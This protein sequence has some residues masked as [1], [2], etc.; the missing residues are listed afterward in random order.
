[1]AMRCRCPPEN[2]V[3]VAVYH[4]R[5]QRHFFEHRR[6]FVGALLP[7]ELRLVHQEAFADDFADGQ[8]WRERAVGILKDDLHVGFEFLP[9]F[10]R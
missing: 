7:R 2:F 3:R 9:R 5:R 10:F 1:M 8:A 4:R 6:D